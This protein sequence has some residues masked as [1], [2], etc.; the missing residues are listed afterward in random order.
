MKIKT[1]SWAIVASMI[2]GLSVQAT[3]TEKLNL[4]NGASDSIL[5]AGLTGT[6]IAGAALT[7]AVGAAATG[8]VGLVGSLIGRLLSKGAEPAKVQKMV[9]DAT[10]EAIQEE[11][12][13]GN[14]LN[15]DL[16][17]QAESSQKMIAPGD[18]IFKA[19]RDKGLDSERATRIA[20]KVAQKLKVVEPLVN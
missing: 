1:I 9:A 13:A 18:P 8:A 6:A 16:D 2:L 4:E 15:S 11:V 17:L 5:I 19:L 3:N 20:E 10:D 7:A 12:A 14:Y